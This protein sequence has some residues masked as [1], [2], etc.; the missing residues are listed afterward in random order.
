MI[1]IPMAGMSARFTK[2]GYNVPKYMLSAKNLSLFEHAVLSFESYFKFEKFV[3][4]IRDIANTKA[5]VME[6]A[7]KLGIQYIEIVTLAEPTRGQAETVYL[8]LAS[9]SLMS[10]SLAKEPIT[11]F[12]IDTFRPHFI[13]PN[14]IDL[15]TSH[16][17]EVFKGTGENWSFVKPKAHTST[18]VI[19]TA[20]KK[21]I[22]NLCCTGLYHFASKQ[23]FDDAYLFYL[24]QPKLWHKNELYIAPI[25]NYLIRKD[26]PV[27]YHLIK[28]NEVIFC[29]V[30]EEYEA[31]KYDCEH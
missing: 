5:F 19:E 28:R 13:Y 24:N 30:P 14:D 15:T 21:A 12:N 29:G 3:F 18:C 9:P 7:K 1:V 16:Y 17:L 22:S 11:I 2:A 8:G 6:K 10:S 27:Y 31:F 25:Y 4:I 26:E 23:A 20:E